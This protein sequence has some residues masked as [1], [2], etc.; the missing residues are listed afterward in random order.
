MSDDTTSDAQAAPAVGKQ[1]I[2]AACVQMIRACGLTL[3]DLEPH[4]RGAQPAVH[5]ASRVP[6]V[7]MLSNNDRR[8]IDAA[9]AAGGVTVG[10]VIE[11]LG[12]RDAQ[13][14]RYCAV[15]TQAGHLT[16]VKKP[17]IRAMHFFSSPEAA[18]AWADDAGAAVAPAAPAAVRTAKAAPLPLAIRTKRVKPGRPGAD[19]LVKGGTVSPPA[20][21][22]PKPARDPIFTDKT[23]H[24]IDDKK[25]PTARWQMRQEAPDE[26]WPSFASAPLGTNPDT[27]KVWERRA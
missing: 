22:M 4:L 27:G 20:P 15:L 21:G 12:L 9:G 1:A 8:V 3:Q 24:T 2:L 25:R 18:R 26:R 16:G 7:R 5:I 11:L 14:H 19:M 23:V 10:G 6:A 17:G 13:A